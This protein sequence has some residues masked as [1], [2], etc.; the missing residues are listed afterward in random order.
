MLVFD[1]QMVFYV[2]KKIL[3]FGFFWFKK[4]YLES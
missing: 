2:N 3:A 4:N 1:G